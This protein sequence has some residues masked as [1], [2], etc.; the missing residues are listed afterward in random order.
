MS[1][2]SIQIKDTLEISQTTVDELTDK[3][4]DQG[5]PFY[6]IAVAKIF[7]KTAKGVITRAKDDVLQALLE[8]GD[9]TVLVGDASFTYRNGTTSH[10][11]SESQEWKKLKEDKQEAEEKMLALVE[12]FMAQSLP[13]QELALLAETLE[14]RRV[15]LEAHL[16]A[17][18]QTIIRKGADTL[19]VKFS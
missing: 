14:R 7:E 8:S 1:N 15:D 6:A 3:L 4:L 17:N 2:N 10:D 12:Q 5:D 19:S 9:K 13:Y 18:G 11:F 16:I